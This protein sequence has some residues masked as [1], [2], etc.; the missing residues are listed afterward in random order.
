[1]S[2]DAG[3]ALAR[4]QALETCA[5]GTFGRAIYDHFRGNGFAFP[6]EKHGVGAMVFHDIG[7]AQ[8]DHFAHTA[9]PLDAVRAK[10][11][12]PKAAQAA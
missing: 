4:Y 11:G 1:M 10:L 8:F 9:M 2:A 5:P 12:I 3:I 6:G 7:L